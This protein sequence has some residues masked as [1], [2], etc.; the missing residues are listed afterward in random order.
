[1]AVDVPDRGPA[2]VHSM[3]ALIVLCDTAVLLRFAS[4]KIAKSGFGY[5]DYMAV[6]AMVRF[7]PLTLLLGDVEL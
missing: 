1:M 7:Q 4:R 6:I 2:L 5:D 3:I